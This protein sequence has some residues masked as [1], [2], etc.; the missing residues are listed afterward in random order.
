MMLF[1]KKIIAYILCLLLLSTLVAGC[2]EV[3]PYANE[4]EIT[5]LEPVGG[6][7]SSFEVEYRDIYNYEIVTGYVTPSITEYAFDSKQTFDRYSV[8]PGEKVNKG[9]I[10]LKGSTKKIEESIEKQEDS[11][12][13]QEETYLETMED[14]NESLESA[15]GDMSYYGQIV[16]NFENMSE[17]EAAAY[18]NYDGNFAKYRNLYSNSDLRVQKI[19]ESIKEKAEL[20][21]LDYGYNLSKLNDLKKD[22]DE[23]TLFAEEAGHVVA[24]NYYE[25]DNTIN[26]DAPVIAVGNLSEKEIC[27]EY[28]TKTTISRCDE[29]YILINGEKY[30]ATYH[31]IDSDEYLRL[32]NKYGV[33]YSTFTIEDPENKVQIGDYATAVIITNSLTNVLCVPKD[34]ISRDETGHY[35]YVINSEGENVYTPVKVGKSDYYYTEILSGLSAGDRVVSEYKVSYKNETAV[36]SK[37]TSSK[38]FSGNGYLYY[39]N[40]EWI[41]NPV[42]YGVTYLDEIMVSKNQ[43]VEAGDEIARIR[44]LAD[45]IN[46][47]RKERELL[48]LNEKLIEL[49][50]NNT[51]NKNQRSI[52]HTNKEIADLTKVIND[53]KKDA[54][55]VVIKAPY[56]GVITDVLQYEEGDILPYEKGVA[57]IASD[58]SSFIIVENKGSQLTYGNPVSIEYKGENRSTKTAEGTVV[59]VNNMALSGDLALDY[60]LISVPDEYIADLVGNTQNSDGWWSRTIYTVNVDTK[61]MDNVLLVPRSCVTDIGGNTYVCVKNADG[62]CT[63]KSFIAGG[64]DNTYYWVVEGLTE[65]MELCLR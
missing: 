17:A 5:L 60:A 16:S 26:K 57:E 63:V 14:L 51:D 12:K 20:Y 45:D 2:A 48:R 27:T 54:A 19:E 49:M 37:G 13:S 38:L 15:K 29:Y 50:E 22:K 36:V 25:K 59:T 47:R 42:E 3:N 18:H 6:F 61:K 65:G 58:S 7:A 4:E 55:T 23:C 41:K 24:I 52:K 21:L 35:V 40:S 34:A 46:I 64:N 39:S 56:K 32:H 33:V 43:T 10:L 28:V 44:V 11:L 8:M 9:D 62:T 31:E 30:K 1:K 53:M